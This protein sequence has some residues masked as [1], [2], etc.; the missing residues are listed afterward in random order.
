MQ[1]SLA[2]A[3]DIEQVLY[4]HEHVDHINGIAEFEFYVRLRSQKPLPIYAGSHTL[5]AI[6]ERFAFMANELEPHQIEAWQILEFDGV[7]YTALPA[8]HGI[9]TFGYLIEKTAETEQAEQKNKRI[10][11]FPDTA[12]PSP[13]VLEQLQDIDILIIDATFY[14]RNWMPASHLTVEEAIALAKQLRAKKTF[15]THLSMHYDEPITALELQELL[16]PYKGDILVANDG[17]ELSF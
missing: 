13:E 6:A 12:L 11:Y 14:G 3:K 8:T 7:R 10:A 9:Q 5:F 1:L 17:L 2:G 16:A 4:T 15:L